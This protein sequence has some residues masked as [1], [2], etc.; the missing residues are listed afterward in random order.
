MDSLEDRIQYQFKRS[1]LLKEA[2]T[3]PSLSIES[4]VPMPHNQRLE[5][6]GDSVL[7]LVLTERLFFQFPDYDEGKLTKLRTRLVQEKALAQVARSIQ[8]GEDLLL[9]KGENLHGGRERNSTLADAMESLLGAIYLDG[10]LQPAQALILRLWDPQWTQILAT[11]VEVNP[12]GLL[13][14]QLQ[15][16]GKPAPTYKILGSH[17]PDHEKSFDAVV[18]WCGEV[19]G[20]GSGSTKKLA[21]IQAATR[22]LES[23][24]VKNLAL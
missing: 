18:L 16:T 10:G 21:E 1:E 20:E 12:K 24:F 17:G 3:H 9:S 8:L 14:E 22:A 7:Q 11:P 5:F 4:K 6:L 15:A 2:L 23:D 13:Q 19:L